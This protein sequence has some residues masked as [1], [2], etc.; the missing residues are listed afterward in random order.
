M[1]KFLLLAVAA[2]L[3]AAGTLA[4]PQLLLRSGVR[5]ATGGSPSGELIG[6]CRQVNFDIRTAAIIGV[7]AGEPDG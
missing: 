1:K 2:I 4:T 7:N 5:E 6:R 3:L